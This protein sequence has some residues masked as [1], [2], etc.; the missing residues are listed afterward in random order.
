LRPNLFWPKI[1]QDIE[2][3]VSTCVLCQ[4]SKHYNQRQT[5]L[6][7]MT[8]EI[9]LRNDVTKAP[10]IWTTYLSLA[11]FAYKSS[12]HRSTNKTSFSLLYGRENG[13][14]SWMLYR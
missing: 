14:I 4:K 11:E 9:M 10:W 13:L 3:Y 12:R 2:A 8:I 6:L 1:K 5:E 7:N